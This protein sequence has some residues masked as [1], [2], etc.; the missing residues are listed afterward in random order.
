VIHDAQSPQI[1]RK[2]AGKL[3]CLNAPTAGFAGCEARNG[4][5]PADFSEKVRGSQGF[6]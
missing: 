3:A 6:H 4:S 5:R 1:S 2:R